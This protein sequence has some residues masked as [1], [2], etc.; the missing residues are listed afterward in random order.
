MVLQGSREEGGG[1]R[2]MEGETGF[3]CCELEPEERWNAVAKRACLE[4]RARDVGRPNRGVPT[5]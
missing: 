4:V 2:T 1:G 5:G 3:A